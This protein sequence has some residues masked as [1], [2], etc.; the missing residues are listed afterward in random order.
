MQA[1]N[2]E[3][4]RGI[5]IFIYCVICHATFFPL[6]F[7]VSIE[8]CSFISDN[9]HVSSTYDTRLSWSED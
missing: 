3:I 9:K 4:K 1:G 2:I 8:D 5:Y 6:F 7:V